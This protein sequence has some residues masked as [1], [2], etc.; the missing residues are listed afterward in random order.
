MSKESHQ[1]S[2]DAA[3]K[4]GV[5]A[6]IIF[7]HLIFL[8]KANLNRQDSWDGH[9]YWIK[10]T[11]RAFEAMYPYL[12]QK[13]IRGALDRLQKEGYILSVAGLSENK[14]DRAKSFSIEQLG[15]DLYEIE[16]QERHIFTCD[17]R[18][19][20]GL[21]KGKSDVTQRENQML[22]KGQMNNSYNSY[23][24]SIKDDMPD[25]SDSPSEKHITET[26]KGEL[27]ALAAEYKTAPDEKKPEIAKTGKKVKQRYELELKIDQTILHLNE[28]TGFRYKLGTEEA[29]KVIRKRLE[30]N[31]LEEVFQV[32]D[33]KS[34]EWKD[35]IKMRGNLVPS[36]L[37]NGH[38]EDY[39]QAA[40]IAKKPS[41]K[42][43]ETVYTAPVKR[44]GQ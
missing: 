34:D 9:R 26:L 21:Q 15:F 30:K 12:S 13:E 28:K 7:G 25:K 44:F 41:K 33:Y 5:N 29:R 16:E 24:D 1:F 6:A 27:D 10:K 3:K 37:F 38:F 40:L 11:A 43:N 8:H 36:T 17:K 42:Q 35:N 19:N 31:T 22:P 18:A 14:F 4:V 39:Y 23:N 2:T 20:A 32:I